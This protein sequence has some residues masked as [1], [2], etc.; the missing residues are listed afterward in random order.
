MR[1]RNNYSP[2]F[3]ARIV[4]ELL[5][6]EKTVS[7]IVS[8]TGI[9][10]TV[11]SRWKAEAIE[12]MHEIF[13]RG[14]SDTEKLRREFEAKEEEYQKAIGELTMDLNFLKKKWYQFGGPMK[15]KK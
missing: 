4:L 5:R 3:K 10:A 8:E 2:E 15:E 9:H 7:Q 11:L 13:Q 12:R 6:E 14:E 1:E